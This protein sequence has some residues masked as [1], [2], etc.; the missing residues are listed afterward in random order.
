VPNMRFSSCILVKA[1]TKTTIN[2]QGSPS[3]GQELKAVP[4]EYEAGHR[5]G[6]LL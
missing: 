6:V 5:L 1:P 4:R 2:F 3:F